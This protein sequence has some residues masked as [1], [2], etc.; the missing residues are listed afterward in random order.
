MGGVWIFDLL[1]SDG[2]RCKVLDL[3]LEHSKNKTLV[4]GN[5]IPVLGTEP[6][7]GCNVF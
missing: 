2:A 7:W 4:L 5:V 6:K 1:L 3:G